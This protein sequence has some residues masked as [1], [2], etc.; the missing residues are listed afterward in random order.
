MLFAINSLGR[1]L[2]APPLPTINSLGRALLAPPLPVNSQLSTLSGG[3]S[4]HRPYLL[5]LNSQ[6]STIY[7]CPTPK[8]RSILRL[9]RDIE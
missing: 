8:L 4:W 2:L 9:A 1:A 5:T 3:H 7:L 6:L